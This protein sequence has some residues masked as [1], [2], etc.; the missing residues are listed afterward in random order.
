MPGRA[1]RISRRRF[2]AAMAVLPV[3]CCSSCTKAPALEDGGAVVAVWDLEDMSPGTSGTDVGELLSCRVIDVLK[4]KGVPVVER[5]H[6]V[7]TLEE[8][9]LGSSTLVDEETRLHVGRLAGARRM[10]FGG[11]LILDAQIRVDLRL[12][13]VETGE[14]LK[15]VE[16]TA[17]G[18]DVQSWLDAAAQAA[19]LLL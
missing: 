3:L 15:A 16:K 14:V 18:S 19:M 7:R 4:G 17:P 10:I 2:L 9:R 13:N 8:L 1:D 12:V 11:Y 5:S 6:L